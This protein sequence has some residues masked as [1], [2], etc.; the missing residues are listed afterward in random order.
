MASKLNTQLLQATALQNITNTIAQGFNQKPPPK[1]TVLVSLDM[2]KAFDTVNIHTLINKLQ[3]TTTPPPLIKYIANYIKGRKAY[4][5][6]NQTNSKQQTL[7]TGVPQGGV[8]SPILFNLYVSDIPQP[9]PNVQMESY[10][11]D[12][13]PLTSHEN[14]HTAVSTLQPYLD[15]IYTWTKSNDLQLNPDKSTCTLFTPDPAEQHIDL[16]LTINNQPIPTVKNPKIL[17]VT[18]DPKLNFNEHTKNIHTAAIKS[19]NII[20]SLTGTNWGKQKET[21]VATYTAI[22][23]P[24]LEYASTVWSSIISDTNTNKLQTIQN[25]ALRI[26]TGCTRD[27]NINHIHQE[28][29][30]LPLKN[31][32]QL[33]ASNLKQKSAS[34]AH[35]LNKLANQPHI[36]NPRKNNEI[37][38]KSLFQCNDNIINPPHTNNLTDTEI[39]QNIK[40]NHFLAV[41]NYTTTRPDNKLLEIPTPYI[42]ISEE[43]LERHQRRLLS[44]LRAN[45]SPFLLAYKHHIDPTSYPSPLCPLCQ[46]QPHNTQHLFQCQHIKT[47]LTPHDLWNSPCEVA[48]LVEIWRDLLDG[49]PGHVGSSEA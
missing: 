40:A 27:T 49:P 35:P 3:E 9:P 41:Q 47:T 11:D 28:T 6:Y 19:T 14:F 22:T 4:T 30:T 15:E 7:R 32:C 23:R 37:K 20:K 8:L 17:G 12:L 44:Q 1:R 26:A 21:I 46:E 36:L 25:T 2:S 42:H 38:K 31:H 24:I 29:L 18:F 48:E 39:E 10:A 5:Q 34:T 16:Q 43:T 45:K 33:H 13:N